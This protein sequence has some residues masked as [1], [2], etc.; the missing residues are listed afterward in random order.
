MNSR[1]HWW[2]RSQ[3][4]TLPKM[5]NK[6]P[7]ASPRAISVSLRTQRIQ[8]HRHPRCAYSGVSL[9]VLL[10]VR[11]LHIQCKLT[12]VYLEVSLT[13]GLLPV[14]WAKQR[15]PNNLLDEG[16]QVEGQSWPDGSIGCR[17]I[18]QSGKW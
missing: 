18:L 10:P 5:Q 9:T 2:R 6:Q 3:M 1:Y 4:S 7:D 13:W 11:L 12:Q 16:E 8:T 15:V 17:A 14:I